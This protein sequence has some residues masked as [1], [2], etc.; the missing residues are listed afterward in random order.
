MTSFIPIFPLDIVVYPGEALNLHIFEPR[1][2]Q[3]IKECIEEEKRFG[4][5][6]VIDKKVQEYGT[7][8]EVT[9][10]VKE[11]ET[12]EMDIR[13]KGKDVFRVLE[14]VKELP[15]KLYSGA[16]VSYPHNTTEQQDSQIAELILKEVKRFYEL[17]N[18][19]D[20]F[21]AEQLDVISYRIAHFIGMSMQQE[22]EMLQLFTETQ[23]LE[24]IRRHLKD[25]V[26]LVTE[27]ETS[28]ARIKM[29]GHFRDLSIDDIDF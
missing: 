8:I 21:P 20:K 10:L 2:K 9:E 25:A 19:E 27:L 3:L 26:P 4:I 18:V 15:E 14:V 6:C 1:Y 24:Y 13:V 11:Y 28:K 16:I 7:S 29:N 12:G 17:L 22:Y 5:P 23:R